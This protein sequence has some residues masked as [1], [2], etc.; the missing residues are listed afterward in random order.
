MSPDT[1]AGLAPLPSVRD[2]LRTLQPSNELLGYYRQKISEFDGEHADMMRKLERYK[3][4]FTPSHWSP[5]QPLE[6]KPP[7]PVFIFWRDFSPCGVGQ[8]I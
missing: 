5:V 2:R 3:V 1:A 8:A 4:F 7:P 6:R